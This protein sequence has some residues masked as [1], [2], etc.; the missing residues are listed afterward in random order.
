MTDDINSFGSAHPELVTK[1]FTREQR[2]NFTVPRETPW[3]SKT[4]SK[5]VSKRPSRRLQSNAEAP[6]ERLAMALCLHVVIFDAEDIPMAP[7]LVKNGP[8]GK[9]AVLQNTLTDTESLK[10]REGDCPFSYTLSYGR[11]D[12]S[13]QE[14]QSS[15]DLLR[16]NAHS[17]I[18]YDHPLHLIDM[19]IWNTK[20]ERWVDGENAAAAGH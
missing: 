15:L 8:D 7:I 18:T 13:I 5:A 1:D 12:E 3:E 2:R 10:C 16:R 6:D 9:P 11:S 20:E 4:A 17:V 14:G 19:Y